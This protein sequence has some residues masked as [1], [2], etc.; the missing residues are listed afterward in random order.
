MSGDKF[1]CCKRGSERGYVLLVLLLFV[2]LLS[3]GFIAIVE[4]LD[5]QIKRDREEELIHR[6]VQ[7]SRAVR[8]FVKKFGHYPDSIEQLENTSNIRFLRKRYKDPISGKDF[9]ILHNADLRGLSSSSLGIP[10]TS[11]AAQQQGA[12]GAVN[13]STTPRARIMRSPTVNPISQDDPTPADAFPNNDG[14]ANVP[15]DDPN[16]GSIADPNGSPSAS[17]APSP[18]EEP[19]SSGSPPVATA[20]GI[21]GVASFNK[22]KTI[23]VFNQQDHYNQWQFV[24]DPSTDR[25]LLKTPHV[26]LLQVV[27]QRMNKDGGSS[28]RSPSPNSE[29]QTDTAPDPGASQPQ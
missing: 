29:Q 28:P 21:I 16:A 17:A 9:K 19:G 3:I 27:V 15:T 23:R 25:G 5:F 4:R 10:V 14:S 24:Y 20:G 22:D 26:P 6:G 7:Y 18:S 8:K 1:R 2:A 12:P 11:I 13:T